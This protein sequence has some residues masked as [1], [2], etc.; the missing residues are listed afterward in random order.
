MAAFVFLIAPDN[1]S[2]VV[3]V[4]A[5]APAS[6]D[7]QTSNV[8]IVVS[9]EPATR[10]LVASISGMTCG[11]CV[12][13]IERKVGALDGVVSVFVYLGQKQGE[14]EYDP[15][16]VSKQTILDTITNYGYPASE[17]S[18]SSAGSKPVVAAAPI[19]SG[20]SSCGGGSGGGCGCGG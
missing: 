1:G 6:S 11:S 17:V 13:G 5:P 20:G 4:S 18:D 16:V 9:N 19:P 7:V 15:A 2:A 3:S 10:T 8:P 12:A 14:V